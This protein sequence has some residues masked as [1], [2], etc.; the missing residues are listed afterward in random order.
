M[1]SQ[2]EDNRKQRFIAEIGNTNSGT[3]E[4]GLIKMLIHFMGK[5]FSYM[6]TLRE[7]NLEMELQEVFQDLFICLTKE[8]L[9]LL[10]YGVCFISPSMY[11]ACGFLNYIKDGARD[12]LHK[13]M[14]FVLLCLGDLTAYAMTYLSFMEEEPF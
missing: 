4:K 2:E 10:D 11:P 12:I 7:Q 6:A 1:L 8:T 13:R 3:A 14:L 5:E 9:Y